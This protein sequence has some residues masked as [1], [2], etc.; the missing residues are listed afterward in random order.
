MEN[1]KACK[2]FLAQDEAQ[3]LCRR[4][5]PTP[6]PTEQGVIS[7]FPPMLNDGWCGEFKNKEKQQ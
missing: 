5:P 7:F 4:N 6:I 1:C 2:F 3:G